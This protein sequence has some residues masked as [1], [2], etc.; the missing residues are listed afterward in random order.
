VRLTLAPL[1]REEFLLPEE[2]YLYRGITAAAKWRSVHNARV[3]KGNLLHAYSKVLSVSPSRRRPVPF[4]S[5][6][7]REYMRRT[8]TLRR[9][10]RSNAPPPARPDNDAES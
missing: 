7:Q 8:S 3:D 1:R 10:T 2:P 5:V 6:Y 4:S 9:N